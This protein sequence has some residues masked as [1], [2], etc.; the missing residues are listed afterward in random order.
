VIRFLARRVTFALVLV[1]LVSSSSLWLTRLAPGDLTASMAFAPAEEVAR[2]RAQFGLDRPIAEQ[3]VDWLR[4]ATRFD[5]GESFLYN[6]S[7]GTLVTRAAA[8]TAA[9]AVVALLIATLVGIPLGI[10]TGSRRGG[11]VTYFVRAVSVLFLSVPPLVMSLVLVWIAARTAWFPVGGMSSAGSGV[12]EGSTAIWPMLI[13]LAWHLPLPALAL[14][15]PIAATLERLQ[16]Q[17][18]SESVAQPFVAAARARGLSPRDLVL[19]HAW[20]ASLRPVCALYGLVIGALLSGSF[21]VEYVTSWPGLGRLMYEALRARDI[22]LV[23]GCAAAGALFLALGSLLSDLLLA[24]AD[25]RV[26]EEPA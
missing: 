8:N 3:W 9:L 26:R 5:F 6:R 10:F 16:S 18:M 21:A 20:R 23:A 24:A 2:V 19:R 13:D 7:V 12:A 11:A 4:R 25:P 22:Y 14:A 1:L 17:S 15:L